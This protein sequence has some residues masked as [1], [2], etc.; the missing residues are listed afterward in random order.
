MRGLRRTVVSLLATAL[1]LPIV[2][3]SPAAAVNIGNEGCTPG[4]WKNH[5][6]DWQEYTTS[7]KLKF[8]FVLGEFAADIGDT[9]FLQA[10][11]FKGGSSDLDAARLLLHHAAAAFLNAA[12]EGVGY[13]YR[14]FNDPGNIQ[15]AVNDALASSDRDTMLEV[16]DWLD[17]ANNLGCPL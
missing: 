8:N 5:T 14:R 11:R 15:Q 4:Y 10:L 9:T 16:K 12:H 2:G 17:A 13:P 6:E 3:L 7:S 1:I